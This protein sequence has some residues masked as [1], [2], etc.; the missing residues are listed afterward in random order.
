MNMYGMCVV[1]DFLGGTYGL[2]ILKEG[3]LSDAKSVPFRLFL[4][5][6]NDIHSSSLIFLCVVH[7][8]YEAGLFQVRVR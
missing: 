1:D 6:F 3:M 7:G 4:Q 5:I 8:L 2:D